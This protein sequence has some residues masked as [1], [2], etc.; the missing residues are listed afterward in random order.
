MVDLAQQLD[1]QQCLASFGVGE[2]ERG[3]FHYYTGIRAQRLESGQGKA[4]PQLFI[5]G[6]SRPDNI[7]EY[8]RVKTAVR[9]VNKG[10]EFTIWQKISR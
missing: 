2:H 1:R 4:C 6:S 9:P 8:Q 5:Q 7:A 10:E 3:N